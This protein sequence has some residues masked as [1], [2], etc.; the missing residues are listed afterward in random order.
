M[1][2]VVTAD[3]QPKMTPTVMPMTT[4]VTIIPVPD[5]MYDARLRRRAPSLSAMEALLAITTQIL[6]I[7]NMQD[8]N[9]AIIEM[10]IARKDNYVLK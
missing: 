8:D 3:V 5:T 4:A 7:I 9:R 10:R 1:T 6:S 2:S